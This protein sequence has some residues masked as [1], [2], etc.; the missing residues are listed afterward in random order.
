MRNPNFM[1]LA[2]VI[3][4]L[5]I[6]ACGPSSKELSGAKTAHYKGDKLVMFGAIKTAVGEKYHIQK[7]DEN[8]L[9]LQTIGRWFTPEGL[10][11]GE[12]NDDMRDVPDKSIQIALV[13]TMQPDG[14]SYVVTV[15]PLMLRFMAGSPKP[16]PLTADDPSVPGW[17]T[18]KVDQ[19]ALDIHTA[20]AQ[21]EVKSVP[22]AA[23]APMAPAPA[24]AVDPAAPAAPAPAAP[25]PAAPAPATP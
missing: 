19:L 5:A 7:S 20:L 22:G 11:A 15:K 17:A 12:R 18:G 21:Y 13:V 1:R 3:A 24:P 14:D 4:A 10:A 16:E 9:G 23:P 8:T 2:M 6:A 25:A